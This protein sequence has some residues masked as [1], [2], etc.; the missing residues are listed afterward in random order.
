MSSTLE[1]MLD[2]MKGEEDLVYGE[3]EEESSLAPLPLRPTSRARLPSSMRA[4]KALG[5]CLDNLALPNNRTVLKENI[6][7]DLS[8]VAN[9][10]SDPVMSRDTPLAEREEN[11]SFHIVSTP[12][13]AQLSTRS[14]CDER[15]YGSTAEQPGFSFLTVQE[16]PATP[17]PENCSLP[18]MASTPS[19]GKKWK[20]DGTLR[21]KKVRAIDPPLSSVFTFKHQCNC[22]HS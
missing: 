16:S 11:G 9:L 22:R 14:N 8:P 3:T 20:D 5:A 21:L 12:V 1:E 6:A 2:S 15:L 7:F 17:V 19:S 18:A 4:K 10:M 13:K